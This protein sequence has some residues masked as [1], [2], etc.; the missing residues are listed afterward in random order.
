MQFD[1]KWPM[2]IDHCQKL[3]VLS[4]GQCPVSTMAIYCTHWRFV[5]HIDEIKLNWIDINFCIS[6]CEMS[7]ASIDWG[8]L[9]VQWQTSSSR[10]RCTG[11]FQNKMYICFVK[12]YIQIDQQN[13]Q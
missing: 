4:T 10:T 3:F 1:I 12:N 6:Y 5:I 9:C 2:V 7:K 13:T 11:K 8:T